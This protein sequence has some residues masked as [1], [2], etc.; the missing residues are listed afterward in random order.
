[1]TFFEFQLYNLRSKIMACDQSLHDMAI[2]FRGAFSEI[3]SCLEHFM[4]IDE[5]MKVND[6]NYLIDTYMDPAVWLVTFIFVAVS[7]VFVALIAVAV[8][9]L[10]Q[11]WRENELSFSYSSR[12]QSGRKWG[13]NAE[14]WVDI[15]KWCM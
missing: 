2:L 5:D 10:Y 1:M 15:Y 14:E 12:R 6:L 11:A 13:D 7:I 3:N 4:R 8:I 9:A